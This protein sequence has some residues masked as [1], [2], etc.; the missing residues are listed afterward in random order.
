MK[1]TVIVVEKSEPIEIKKK[2]N[3][4]SSNKNNNWVKN[5]PPN[6]FINDLHARIYK[7]S[8]GINSASFVK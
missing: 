6:K 7:G 3:I 5:S 1:H 2:Y 4:L 8:L